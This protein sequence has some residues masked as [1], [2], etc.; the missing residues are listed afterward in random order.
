MASGSFTGTTNNSSIQSKISW[1]ES[2]TNVSA[3]T[4]QVTVTLTYSRTNTGY[5]TYGT[6]AGYLVIQADNSS[7]TTLARYPAEGT[8]SKQISITY[9]SNTVAI[10]QTFTITHKSD[11]SRKLYITAE[12]GISGTSFTSTYIS[13]TAT[14]D[15]I[16]TAYRLTLTHDSYSS[17][18]VQRGGVDITNGVIYKGETLTVTFSANSGYALATHTVNGTTKASGSTFTV[19][20]DTTVESTAVKEYKLSISTTNCNVTVT[21]TSSPI[22]GA[23]TVLV[24]N[25]TLYKGDV[26]RV[27]FSPTDSSE[28]ALST[29]TVNG[30][31]KSSGSSVTVSGNVAVVGSAVRTSTLS[32]N[33]SGCTITVKRTSSP[34]G[35][36]GT[37][38]NGATMYYG[39][40]FTVTC[41]ANSGY[42]PSSPTPTVTGASLPE[43]ATSPYTV[44]A[45][46]VTVTASATP[47]VSTVRATNANIG[48]V[49]TITVTRQKNTYY[50]SLHVYLA[51]DGL[52]DHST[53]YITSSGGYQLNE[54]CFQATT[55]SWTV[56]DAFYKRMSTITSAI[57][58]I[59]CK[60]YTGNGTGEIG[61]STCTMTVTATGAP[62]VNVT[63]ADQNSS[64]VSNLTGDATRIIKGVSNAQVTVSAKP[65]HYV[66]AD[67]DYSTIKRIYINGVNQA[68]PTPESGV[69]TKSKTFTKSNESSFY[70]TAMDSRGYS[71]AKTYPSSYKVIPYIAPTCSITLSWDS[72]GEYDASIKL[73]LKGSIY[74][75]TGSNRFDGNTSASGSDNSFRYLQYRYRE[76]GSSTWTISYTTPSSIS[77]NNTSNSYSATVIIPGLSYESSYS[78]QVRYQDQV[79]RYDDGSILTV[80]KTLSR[81]KPIFDW[82]KNDFNFNVPVNAGNGITTTNLTA[83]GTFNQLSVVEGLKSVSY[84]GS[85]DSGS[86]CSDVNTTLLRVTPYLAI[87]RVGLRVINS[88]PHRQNT[89]EI[90]RWAGC[91]SNYAGYQD[92]SLEDDS[93]TLQVRFNRDSSTSSL[94]MTISNY[95]GT[96]IGGGTYSYVRA[97][98]PLVTTIKDIA[99]ITSPAIT[100]QPVSTAANSD[101]VYFEVGATAPSGSTLTYQWWYSSNGSTW[102]PV[103]TATGRDTYRL[104]F[105]ASSGANG[106]LYR[107]EISDGTTTVTSNVA[108]Y[109][110]ADGVKIITQPASQSVSSG[111]PVSF[112]VVA[113]GDNQLSGGGLSYQWQ[114]SDDGTTWTN[115]SSTGYN[116]ATMSFTAASAY[117]GRKYRCIVTAASGTQETSS[118]ATLTVT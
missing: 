7:G 82:G 39:D 35:S 87:C 10:S 71:S 104:Q 114:R 101:T 116:T 98:I 53:G 21:R 95:S 49:S 29:H 81:A 67:D 96:A 84:H 54:T 103:G 61:T 75:G 19:S 60:T 33:A 109:Y 13:G 56:P 64:I 88:I 107:C 32:I 86:Y 44:N 23:S 70:A 8:T 36:T 92:V 91:T 4:S 41:T 59:T 76:S 50:H 11:G 15:T 77:Y 24:N 3:N 2:N 30:V 25:S 42:T 18:T 80:S 66:S 83:T 16:Q 12:G 40:V 58:T 22:S 63:L 93:G 72:I 110:Y 43:G 74:R 69:Y 100:L 62:I 89:I 113:A 117:D 68:L 111:T 45:S 55:I 52:H 9:N 115:A 65:A 79:M 85:G 17:I 73:V 99:D 51:G 48:S 27:T 112:S 106:R 5:E 38:S 37:I 57:C 14:L 1:S 105:G 102:N 46:S 118:A 90:C 94:V 28:Y 6:W 20:G 31:T 108:G 34:V 26:I 97:M 47:G 78:F